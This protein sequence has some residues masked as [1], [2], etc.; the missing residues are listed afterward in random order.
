MSELKPCPF[1]G[2]KPEQYDNEYACCTGSKCP[3]ANMVID[4]RVWNNRAVLAQEAGKCEP[5]AWTTEKPA[6]PGAYWIRGFNLSGEFNQA[7]LVQ[8]VID[9]DA[10][11]LM[12]NLH[13][14]T[15]ETDTGYWYE[16]DDIND[17]FE[18]SGPLYTSPPAPVSVVLPERKPMPDQATFVG[19]NTY[20]CKM[21]D[22]ARG[23]NQALD[24]VQAC[25]NKVKEL[26][27]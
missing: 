11:A 1:C 2:S 17:D 20:F 25:L 27:Q 24:D 4:N 3:M 22:E 15:T 10:Q 5:V 7:A 26:N 19:G 6:T 12:V 9:D 14:S 21:F 8:V 16:V 23:Y 18:W 13:Q